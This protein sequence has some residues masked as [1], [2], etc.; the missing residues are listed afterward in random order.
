MDKPALVVHPIHPLIA[1]RWSPVAFSDEPVSEA[2]LDSCFEA[3]RWA[4]S[5]FNAQPWAFVVSTSAD[6]EQRA[7]FQACLVPGNH[8]WAVRAPVLFFA[9]ALTHF[10]HN[11]KPNR[12]ASYDLGAAMA[13]FSLEATSRGLFVHQMGG[14]DQDKAREVCGLPDNSQV[15]AAV[16]VGR[17]GPADTLSEGLQGRQAGARARKPQDAF[18]F[19]GH[20]K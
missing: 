10:E 17:A 20:W 12:W 19:R 11:G 7:A 8:E 2:D 13:S 6:S 3:A 5:C 15:L 1:A 4:A 16:A 9:V 18:V 14:F